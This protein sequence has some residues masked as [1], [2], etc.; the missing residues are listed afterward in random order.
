ML[1]NFDYNR[2]DDIELQLI[3]LVVTD[4]INKFEEENG[5]L[6]PEQEQEVRARFTNI[7]EVIEKKDPEVAS[8]PNILKRLIGG[9]VR[10]FLENHYK[11]KVSKNVYNMIRSFK[12]L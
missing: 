10:K 4:E 2:A 3:N 8:K 11:K 12:S 6:T 1:K 9:R 5:D 7:G